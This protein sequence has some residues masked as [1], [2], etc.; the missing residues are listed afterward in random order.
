MHHHS[1]LVAA[2][3]A[4]SGRLGQLGAGQAESRRGHL[5]SIAAWRQ[6]SPALAHGRLGVL[7]LQSLR[8]CCRLTARLHKPGVPA[9]GAS[10]RWTIVQTRRRGPRFCHFLGP[11]SLPRPSLQGGKPFIPLPLRLS[12]TF[13]IPGTPASGS[14]GATPQLA[15]WASGP[16]VICVGLVPPAAFIE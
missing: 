1:G 4:T 14:P 7:G 16:R 10:P 11:Y 2:G 3:G 15:V 9:R 8:R 6:G 13:C 5:V 12:S